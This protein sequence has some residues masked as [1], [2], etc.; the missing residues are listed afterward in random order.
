MKLKQPAPFAEPQPRPSKATG[1]PDARN[2]HSFSHL[3]KDEDDSDGE[4]ARTQKQHANPIQSFLDSLGGGH[5][6]RLRPPS[7]AP[8]DMGPSLARAGG[9]DGDGFPFASFPGMPFGAH[10]PGLSHIFPHGLMG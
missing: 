9:G 6:M 3:Q 10:H 8:K 7:S 4:D 1:D 2:Q 5:H